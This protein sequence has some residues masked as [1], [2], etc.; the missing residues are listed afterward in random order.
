[1]QRVLWT[2]PAT[3]LATGAAAV[4]DSAL[5]RAA[6]P[7]L[8]GQPVFPIEHELLGSLSADTDAVVELS[9]YRHAFVTSDRERADLLAELAATGASDVEIQ[10]RPANAVR[11]IP[12]RRSP[13]VVSLTTDFGTTPDLTGHQQY[14]ADAPHGIGVGAGWSRPGGTGAADGV[15]RA[16]RIVD[17]ETGWNPRHEDLRGRVRGPITGYDE[18]VPDHGTAVLGVLA[19]SNNRFGTIGI[20]PDAELY[21]AGVYYAEGSDGT[22]QWNTEAAIIEALRVLGGGD[23]LVLELHAPHP[24]ALPPDPYQCGFVAV[25]YWSACHAAVAQAVSRGVYVVAAAGNGAMDLDDPVLGG[26]FS[27]ARDPGSILVGAGG[28]GLGDVPAG[29]R[30]SFSNYGRRVTLQGWGDAVAT[31]GGLSEGLYHDLYHGGTAERCYTASFGGTSSATPIVAGVV[32]MTSSL[33]RAAG[34]PPLAPRQMRSLLE[35]TSRGAGEGIGGTPDVE[36]IIKEL[37]L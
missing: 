1:M 25:E 22:P 32:A 10:T 11:L 28:S 29:A 13:T 7:G 4:R 6:E 3:Q 2:L 8:I 18:D 12:P 17:V 37:G 20:V 30:H 19:A 21:V 23:V 14:L 15:A 5:E 34:R 31:T 16:I 27:A 24:G 35:K 36:A 26:R 9:S 33:L